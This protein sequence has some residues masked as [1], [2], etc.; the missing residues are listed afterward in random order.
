M[1]ELLVGTKKGLFSSR[2]T[3]TD[4]RSPRG[5]SPA[6][7][8][9][10][11]CAIPYGRYLTSVTS[12][13]YGPRIWVTDDPTGEWQQAEGT[14]L[15][16]E[17]ALERLWVIV[18]GEE[19]GVLYTG[20]DPGPLRESRRRPP[21][22]LNRGLWDRPTRPDWSRQRRPVPAHDRAVARRPVE[23]ARRDLRGGR[24]AHRGRRPDL[25]S[26]QRRDRA[27]IPPRRRPRQPDPALRP[28]RAPRARPPRTA[29]HAMEAYTDLTT[30][31][32]VDRHRRGPAVRLRLPDR[33]RPADP[34]SAFVIP[35]IGAE[36]RT[37]PDGAMRV[38][39]TRD[40]GAA[41]APLGDGLPESDAYL[42]IL[43]EAF[44]SKGAGNGLELYSARRPA[45]C[46]A[47]A[48]RARRGARSAT[49]CRRCTPCARPSAEVWRP[50][51]GTGDP[52]G[53]SR[54]SSGC[55]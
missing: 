46:S 38:W 51:P 8:S 52:A 17:K 7:A 36:D 48:T 6:R 28:R 1:T 25:A 34:D 42:T 5:R 14:V 23:A 24:L 45:R 41:Q 32:I 47:R 9:S 43:R 15:P 27:R 16:E 33:G 26:R 39:G 49:T 44:D 40:A 54:G 30:E 4:S 35:L 12:W 20:G 53:L 31:G 29:V 3:A 55:P 11:R 10:T 22:A 21:W 2:E 18:P 19:N 50:G 37:P 13:F